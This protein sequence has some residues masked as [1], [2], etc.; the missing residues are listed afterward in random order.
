MDEI[1]EGRSI[2]VLV[3]EWFDICGWDFVEM[4]VEFVFFIVI[5]WMSGIDY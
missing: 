2:V 1:V 4:Y 3:K 5:I